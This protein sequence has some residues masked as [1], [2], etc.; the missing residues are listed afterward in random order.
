MYPF[1]RFLFSTHCVLNMQG[2]PGGASGKE[3]AWQC[4]LDVRDGGSIPELGTFPGERTGSP[5]QYSSL[6][7]PNDRGTWRATVHRVAQLLDTTE[8]T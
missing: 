5:L 1:D 8:A 7:N 4:R 3:P 6:E 2:F